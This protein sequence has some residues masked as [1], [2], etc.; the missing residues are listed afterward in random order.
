MAVLA[1]LQ[2]MSPWWWV[3]FALVLGTLEMLSLA[4]FLI[5]PAIAAFAMSLFLVLFPDMPGSIQLA[6]FSV[7]SVL[8]T[9][10]FQTQRH[11]LQP[12]QG[13]PNGLNDRTRAMVG[14]RGTI[15]SFSHGRGTIEV[16]GIHWQ[17]I[18]DPTALGLRAGADIE[19]AGIDGTRLMIRRLTPE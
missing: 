9:L 11:R 15:I 8:L 16:D 19:V 10:G 2:G 4:F 18:A 3:A 17:A 7:M 12:D 13:K 1:L 14:R 6:L 5:G